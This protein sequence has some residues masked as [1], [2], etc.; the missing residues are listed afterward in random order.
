MNTQKMLEETALELVHGYN[1]DSSSV[2]PTRID[3]FNKMVH[4]GILIGLSKIKMEDG[5]IIIPIRYHH[6]SK[7]KSLLKSIIHY[8]I[9]PTDLESM[10]DL[11]ST[12]VNNIIG[13]TNFLAKLTGDS[14]YK[15]DLLGTDSDSPLTEAERILAVR[16]I[17]EKRLYVILTLIISHT[18]LTILKV[19][20]LVDSVHCENLIGKCQHCH[21]VMSAKPLNDD[22]SSYLD[23]ADFKDTLDLAKTSQLQLHYEPQLVI[24]FASNDTSTPYKTIFAENSPLSGDV[25]NVPYINLSSTLLIESLHSQES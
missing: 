14:T 18:E 24:R 11:I 19:G 2:E 6:L 3:L 10:Q 21:I 4:K 12:Y 15:D 7:I 20:G 8:R 22:Q 23:T 5:K 17:N 9:D 1:V 13:S 16:T 25:A